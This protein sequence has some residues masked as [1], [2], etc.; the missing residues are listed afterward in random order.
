MRRVLAFI[1]LGAATL[2][3]AGANFPRGKAAP[4]FALKRLDGN[5]LSLR[6]LRGKVVFLDFWGPS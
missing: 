3:P 6:S 2:S 1:A 4:S 5:T